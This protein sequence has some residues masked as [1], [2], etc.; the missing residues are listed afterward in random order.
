MDKSITFIIGAGASREVGLPVGSELKE[1]ISECVR[2]EA[3]DANRY[4]AGSHSFW[5]A[6]QLAI[7]RGDFDLG[8][9]LRACKRIR[10]AMPQAVSIDQFIDSAGV[11]D[12]I[13]T[14]GKVAIVDQILRAERES[15]LFIDSDH[16]RGELIR[17]AKGYWLHTFWGRLTEGAH[18]EDLSVRLKLC[19]F[20]IF[21][22]D[23]CIEHYLF[24]AIKNYYDASDVDAA[25]ILSAAE[26]FHPYGS[27][28][29]LP[30]QTDADPIPFGAHLPAAV[31]LQSAN[32]IKTFTEVTEPLEDEIKKIQPHV[33][34]A[35]FLVFLGFGYHPTNLNVLGRSTEITFD[36]DGRKK[37]IGSAYEI[38]ADDQVAIKLELCRLR[39][40]EA[41]GVELRNVTSNQLLQDFGRTVVI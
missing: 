36:P 30:W 25:A 3:I 33:R 22:Y 32:R 10:N 41:S 17:R 38:S 34:A 40:C 37:T 16:Q 14:V 4:A 2:V 6:V 8:Q 12:S 31:L 11:V 35:I 26:F 7:E 1:R 28:G 21:N 20:V 15:T 39:G 18:I 24:N 29:P 19:S 13:P 5:S 23:R 9:A 27:I